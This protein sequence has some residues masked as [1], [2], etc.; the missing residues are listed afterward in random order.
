[1]AKLWVLSDPTADAS[2]RKAAPYLDTPA[3][4]GQCQFSPDGR[5][6]AYSSDES[7][8]GF[9]VYVQSFPLGA[10]KFQVSSNGGG[11]P[12]WRRDGK[13]LFYVAADGMMMAVNVKTAPTFESEVPHALFDPQITGG[14]ISTF[15]YD[16]TPDGQ[17]FLVNATPPAESKSPEP[18]TVLV[19]WEAGLSKCP[20]TNHRALPHHLQ[21]RRRQEWNDRPHHC[22]LVVSNIHG[23]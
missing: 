2:K 20:P 21:A 12:R 3:H 11:M 5:W 4:T 16:L 13:D 23:W 8:H 18:I 15:R 9:E 7:K 14:A 6:V 10:G 19:N 17:R 22:G 1:L